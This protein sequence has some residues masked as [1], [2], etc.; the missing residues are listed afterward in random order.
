MGEVKVG[1]KV[2][3]QED[4]NQGRVLLSQ[5]LTDDKDVSPKIKNDKVLNVIREHILSQTHYTI[6]IGTGLRI[7]PNSTN[8]FG[9]SVYSLDKTEEGFYLCTFRDTDKSGDGQA[10]PSDRIGG[11]LIASL[12]GITKKGLELLE[13]EGLLV[14]ADAV[15]EVKKMNEDTFDVENRTMDDGEVLTRINQMYDSKMAG[16]TK[17]V[18]KAL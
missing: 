3:K 6:D 10:H 14:D 4:G 1:K 11:I 12:D 9:G 15:E 8:F 2:F 18:S 5:M 7:V 17:K 13:E 16:K